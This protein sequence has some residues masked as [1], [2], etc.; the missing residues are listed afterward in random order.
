MTIG[1]RVDGLEVRT[2]DGL[3][4]NT[5]IRN[6]SSF[7]VLAMHIKIKQDTVWKARGRTRSKT[8]TL[9]SIVVPGSDVSGAEQRTSESGSQRGQDAS[10]VA[11]GEARVD[12]NVQQQLAA[13]IGARL[14][15]AVPSSALLSMKTDDIEVRHWLIMKLKTAGS[16]STPNVFNYVHI[17][18]PETVTAARTGPVEQPPPTSLP[19]AYSPPPAYGT[20]IQMGSR[21]DE[22]PGS[23]PQMVTAMGY[24]ITRPQLQLPTQ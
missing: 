6:D 16:S 15:I 9:A 1:F 13:G 22:M 23:V 10:L 5:A 14:R 12:D 8:R 11:R 18:P 4:L 17:R 21:A 24:S 19:P 3:E 20:I 7:T 2:G